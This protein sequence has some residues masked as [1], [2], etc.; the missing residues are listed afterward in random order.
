MKHP[1]AV[2]VI[3]S[4]VVL[5]GCQDVRVGNEQVG[6]GVGA[7][8]GGLL[9]AQVG[10]GS[11]QIAAAVAGALVG[12]YIGGNIGRT[13]DEVD[14]RKANQSLEVAPTGQTTSWSNPDSGNTYAV[15]PTRTYNQ[16][17]QPCRDYTTE[18]WIDGRKEIITGT[19]CRDAQ[20]NWRA[21]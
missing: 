14:R 4:V 11:G 6:T 21:S 9:G 19:A 2:M 10:G 12:A 13:M 18:A 3:T 7:A 16:N 1:L 5:A 8:L 15:T 17:A 20:G